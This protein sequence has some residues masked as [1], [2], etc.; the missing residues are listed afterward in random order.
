MSDLLDDAEKHGPV[1]A[2]ITHVW[3]ERCPD[4]EPNCP[5]CRAWAEFDKTERLRAALERAADALL[6]AED[7]LAEYANI[8][9]KEPWAA[10][11][12]SIEEKAARAT[13]E[14]K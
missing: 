13:L 7:V 5:C 11:A 14:E 2:A 12:T 4:F 8:L 6:R 1:Y 10:D 3:G 9:S